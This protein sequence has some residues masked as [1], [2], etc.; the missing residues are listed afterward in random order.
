MDKAVHGTFVFHKI[1]SKENPDYKPNRKWMYFIVI[2]ASII[3]FSMVG[4]GMLTM[5]GVLPSTEVQAGDEIPQ[6]RRYQS[7]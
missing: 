4:L 2:P 5:V 6:L 3:L 1:E 7:A